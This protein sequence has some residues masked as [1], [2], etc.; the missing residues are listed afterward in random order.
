MPRVLTSEIQEFPLIDPRSG[1]ELVLFFRP[2]LTEERLAFMKDTV[3]T[4]PLEAK[5]IYYQAKLKYGELILE[6][7]GEGDF[8]F[9]VSGV[10]KAISSDPDSPDYDPNWKGLMMLY[11]S[12]LVAFM[13][14]MVFDQRP[15]ALARRTPK[16]K[17]AS[18]E[19]GN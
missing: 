8:V 17:E 4:D 1:D 9:Q 18:G 13:G 2:P 7:I 3:T 19:P 16:K 5:L 12:E 14:E 11:A 10:K 15:V 6:G